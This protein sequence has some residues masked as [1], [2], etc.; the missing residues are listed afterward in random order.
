MYEDFSATDPLTQQAFH[1]E[2]QCLMV[3]VA[4]RHSDTVD[5]KFL[6]NGQGVW[7]GLPHP[8]WAEFKRA[9]GTALSD[10][11]AVDLAGAYLKRAIESG[12]GA[13]SN[14]WND[15]TV[16][17]VMELAASLKWIPAEAGRRSA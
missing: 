3:G 5:I 14:H 8:A 2:F 10:R 7:L 9:S 16:A 1:C 4:T 17:E 11:M 15:I 13:E 6:V 12:V